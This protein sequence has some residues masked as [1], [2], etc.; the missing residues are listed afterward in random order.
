MIAIV[1]LYCLGLAGAY[2]SCKI[3][4]TLIGGSSGGTYM[5]YFY[6][7]LVSTDVLYS[8][9]K[10]MVFVALTTFIQCYYGFFASGGP[11]GVGVAAGRAIKMCIITVVFANMFLTLAIWGITPGIRISG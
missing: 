3:T 8:L 9:M 5:H 11:E 1:P 7:F 2:I 10:A 4:V 6:Q